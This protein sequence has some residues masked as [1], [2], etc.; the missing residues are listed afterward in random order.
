MPEWR[1]VY[2]IPRLEE[3]F[4][5]IPLGEE[6]FVEARVNPKDIASVEPGQEATIKLSA[7]DLNLEP[8]VVHAKVDKVNLA[9]VSPIA[10]IVEIPGEGAAAYLDTEYLIA[11]VSE[12]KCDL[13]H[14]GY[15]FLSE[16]A[17]FAEAVENVGKIW[18]GPK[19]DQ[20]RLFGNKLSAKD[21]AE[22]CGVPVL[23]SS[24][25]LQKFSEMEEYL[26]EK[27]QG[28]SFLLKAAYGGGG[29]G[30]REVNDKTD[31]EKAF[32]L[33]QGEAR[34]VSRARPPP[35]ASSQPPPTWPPLPG[36]VG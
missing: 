27:S 3:I 9:A 36:R 34:A 8:I 4:E 30:I 14:P 25:I 2:G 29:R 19:V 15:G 11:L 6:L 12:L 1:M 26:T 28:H 21:H 22:K 33:A 16:N 32:S 31:I 35:R 20:L 23:K 17:E 18:V 7:Y 10:K 24:R 5:I 13:V